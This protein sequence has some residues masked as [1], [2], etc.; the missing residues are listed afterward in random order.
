LALSHTVTL[1]VG[2]FSI[3]IPPGSFREQPDGSFTLGGDQ[4]RELE[5]ADYHTAPY[6]FHVKATGAS[7]TGTKDYVTL[8]ISGDGGATSVT[9]QIST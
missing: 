4:W 5:G 7:L 6:A 9:A 2:I 1:E 3:T 8:I